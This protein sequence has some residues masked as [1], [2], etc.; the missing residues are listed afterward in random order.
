MLGVENA[1]VELAGGRR[2]GDHEPLHVVHFRWR[3]MWM[4]PCELSITSAE[5]L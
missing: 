1:Q 5:V 4:G 3:K 2:L